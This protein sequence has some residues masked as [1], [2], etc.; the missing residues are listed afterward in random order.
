MLSK[1]LLTFG[2]YCATMR[3]ESAAESPLPPRRPIYLSSRPEGGLPAEVGIRCF[4]SG[5]L[6]FV[7][8]VTALF[9]PH[10]PFWPSL[11]STLRTLP[12][13]ERFLRGVHAFAVFP[14][15]VFNHLRALLHLRGGGREAVSRSKTHAPNSLYVV[16]MTASRRQ[17][18]P[19]QFFLE[20]LGLFKEREMAGV[21][22]PD[23]AFL[24]C[25]NGLI[26]FQNQGGAAELVV[27]SFKEEHGNAEVE[28]E[29]LQIE[30]RELG[31]KNVE[32]KPLAAEET[33]VVAKGIV[34]RGYDGGDDSLDI[35]KARSVGWRREQITRPLVDEHDLS[36]IRLRRRVGRN[37]FQI[38]GS[39]FVVRFA[40]VLK[41]IAV[42][43]RGILLE[44]YDLADAY[45]GV[46]ENR[47][48]MRQ[49]ETENTAPGMAENEDFL[50]MKAVAKVVDD[51]EGVLL[52]SGDVHGGAKGFLVV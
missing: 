8:S 44:V 52:H 39:L 26:V 48:F 33:E 38:M 28:P 13:P 24:R 12:C 17:N 23:E 15:L 27:S 14:S 31:K 25:L 16:S 4:P 43:G 3:H 49:P 20:L 11:F 6:S 40:G 34:R 18:L 29:F 2:N 37:G 22:K 45:I 7:P 50:A 21:L 10:F 42:H 9:R 47:M 1:Y 5:Y 32:R 46:K 36:K 35:G 19:D 51:F 41:G 30:R